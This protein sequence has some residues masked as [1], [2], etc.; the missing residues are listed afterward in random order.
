MWRLACD[1]EGT[2]CLNP[3]VFRGGMCTLTLSWVSPLLFPWSLTVCLSPSLP[4][5]F[6]LPSVVVISN[7]TILHTLT[8]VQHPLIHTLLRLPHVVCI[9]RCCYGNHIHIPDYTLP[10]CLFS[11]SQGRGARTTGLDAMRLL[12]VIIFQ[13]GI[14]AHMLKQG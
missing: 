12:P 6:H 5:F 1:G 13:S 7:Y 3:W 4:P 9:A 14:L 10:P 8:H 11:T 2:R